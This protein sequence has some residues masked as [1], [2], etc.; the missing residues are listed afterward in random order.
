MTLNLINHDRRFAVEQ[1][2]FNYFPKRDGGSA[3][4]RLSESGRLA[5]AV[6]E[7]NGSKAHGRSWVPRGEKPD[8]ALRM[9]FYRA[10]KQLA[11]PPPWGA[12]T[13]VRPVKKAIGLLDSGR[14]VEKALQRLYDVT[15]ARSQMAADCAVS[16]VSLRDRLASK[17][18]ALYIGI[19]FCPTRC[20]YCSFVSQSVGRDA[21]LIG[22]YIDVLREEI[23]L[24]GSMDV[25]VRAVYWGGGTPA[26]LSA[27]QFTLL[28]DAVRRHFALEHCGEYTVEAGRPD[29]ITG[30][31]LA[32]YRAGGVT[33]VSVN[34]QSLSQDILDAIG[35]KHTPGQFFTAF[36]QAR[37]AGF[38]DIN[39]DLIA[40]LPGDSTENFLN[41]LEQILSLA[42][43][44]I[45]I[46]TLA[47]KRSSSLKAVETDICPPV[48]HL[49]ENG[50][51]P[52]YLYRQKFT[53]GGYENTGWTKPG[54]EC[55]Y[56]LCM[57]EELTTVL[58]LGA[59]GVSKVITG[60]RIERIMHC[61]YPLEYIERRDTIRDKLAA[62]AGLYWEK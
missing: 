18:I 28:A 20:T 41:G 40:G 44:N 38:R 36:E 15:P 43:E 48:S 16:A 24:A 23:A 62:F 4:V 31:K 45:T 25:R 56:N 3:A 33:R 5:S 22:R 17:D 29:A 7:Y 12:L 27:A 46:H 53:E 54:H 8:N 6:I 52:Y 35:R 21:G 39:V 50:Y 11:V 58:S 2:V 59:G 51:K 14:N 42:P 32:A 9:A 60:G 47:K 1:A 26:V 49:Y 19:P 10:A 34:P 57:M 61:K 13:G 30:E 55:V 37:T